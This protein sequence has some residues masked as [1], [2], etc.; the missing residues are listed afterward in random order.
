MTTLVT[1]YCLSW[2]AAGWLFT[3][4]GQ[5][6]LARIDRGIAQVELLILLDE[7]EEGK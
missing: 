3:M 5:A 6:I 2:F 1:A 7:L 4:L